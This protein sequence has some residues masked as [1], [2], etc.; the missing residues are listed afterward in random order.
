MSRLTRIKR[1]LAVREPY[2]ER[3]KAKEVKPRTDYLGWKEEHQRNY[4][5]KKVEKSI[6]S[7]KL[8]KK[9]LEK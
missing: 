2:L 3:L 7:L 4:Q 9:E 5:I 1:I 6:N 8:E